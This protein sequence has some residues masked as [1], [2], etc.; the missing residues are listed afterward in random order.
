MKLINSTSNGQ[1]FTCPCQKIVHLEFGNLF[2]LLTYDEFKFLNNYVKN[3]DYKHFLNK[4]RN[5]QN[6]RKLLLHFGKSGA[7]L[8]LHE[9]EFIEFKS[10]ISLKNEGD[11]LT[12]ISIN[13]SDINLN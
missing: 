8:A 1:I 6:R 3:I 11:R 4:N 12:S 9:N 5:A 13:T 7:Y 2:L 10:L